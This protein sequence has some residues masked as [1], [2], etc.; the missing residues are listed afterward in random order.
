MSWLIVGGLVCVGLF[1]LML[2]VIF[3]ALY[4]WGTL[5]ERK[6]KRIRESGQ[7]VLA[8]IVM[9]NPQFVRDE[10]MAMAPA[11]ALYSLDPP[12]ATL[13]ADMAETAAELFSL[14]T[15]EPSKIASLPTAV[16]QI[17]ERLKDDDYQENRRTRV[18]RE[19]SQGHVLYIAD[20]ILRR[21]YLPEGFMFSKHMACVVTGQDEGQILPLEADDEIAQQIFESAQS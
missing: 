17:A 2:V 21:R 16:R 10:E 14:Y 1:V 15:T 12:S 11:L 19:M 9:V 20:M 5:I 3:A 13:A 6:E 4:I 8:V 18:P 7:P